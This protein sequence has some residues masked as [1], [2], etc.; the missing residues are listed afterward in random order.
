MSVTTYFKSFKTEFL[1]RE[2]YKSIAF[3]LIILAIA[4]A[5]TTYTIQRGSQ[6]APPLPPPSTPIPSP[7]PSSMINSP[8]TTTIVFGLWQEGKAEIRAVNADGTND[9]AI[10]SLPTNSKD[11]HL[12]SKDKLL[13]ITETNQRDHGQKIEIYNLTDG[14]TLPLVQA[15]SDWG[16]DD[17]IV[18]PD[19]TWIAWW[20][21]KFAPGKDIL[22][23]GN[24]RVYTQQLTTGFGSNSKN[25]IVNEVAIATPIHYPLFFDHQNRLYLDSFIPNGGGWNLGLVRVDGSTLT[26][27][28]GMGDGEFSSDPTVSPQGDIIA[29][30]GYDPD[31]SPQRRGED[32]GI[33]R[34][35]ILNPNLLQTLD[36]NTLQKT[37]LLLSAGGAQYVLPTWSDDGQKIAF[38]KYKLTSPTL[39]AFEETKVLLD[40]TIGQEAS[41]PNLVGTQTYLLAFKGDELIWGTISSD[42]FEPGNLGETYNALLSSISVCNI[43]TLEKKVLANG[44]GLQFIGIIPKSPGTALGMTISPQDSQGDKSPTLQFKSFEV[45]QLAQARSSQQNDNGRIRCRD[46]LGIEKRGTEEW[47][48]AFREGKCYDSPLYLYPQKDTWVEVRVKPP[49]KIIGASPKYKERWKVLAKPDGKLTTSDSQVFNKISY[50]YSNP[51]FVPPSSGVVVERRGLKKKLIEYA[52]TLGLLGREV[53]DFVTFWQENLPSSPYYFISHF[54]QKIATQIMPLEVDPRP[55]TFIQAVMYFRPLEGP[56]SVN[57]PIFDSLP[58]REGFVVV[59]WS[60]IIDY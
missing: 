35:A 1:K 32:V 60:G 27:L 45:K 21:V 14:S 30:T 6:P 7:S 25:L 34:K 26:P 52:K 55:D 56:L 51:D 28:S 38:L 39:L 29:F 44:I 8:S 19:K 3:L 18:S 49:V 11:V 37:T 2:R 58:K 47:R 54:S 57:F 4:A 17:V 13:Y 22:L 48:T 36:L 23:G 43:N 16:I 31:A 33:G 59:D 53:D 41:I 10:A 40:L 15:E 50:A 12:I 42:T 20:E 46:I 9:K 5:G 24:S